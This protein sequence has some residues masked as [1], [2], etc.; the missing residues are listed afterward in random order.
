MVFDWRSADF[1]FGYD[2]FLV[3]TGC[4]GGILWSFSSRNMPDL[5][6]H[7]NIV[8]H[9]NARFLMNDDGDFNFK[10]H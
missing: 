7:C 9:L 6:K 4:D 10:L 2:V 5:Q 1:T 3:F 8:W